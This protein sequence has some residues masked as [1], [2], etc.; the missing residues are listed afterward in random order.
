MHPPIHP[1]MVYA[2]CIVHRASCIVH[3]VSCIVRGASCVVRRACVR[4]C[5]VHQMPA[6][7]R[8]AQG[9]LNFRW[10]HGTGAWRWRRQLYAVRDPSGKRLCG[11]VNG[12]VMGGVL[13]AAQF[14]NTLTHDVL[15]LWRARSVRPYV[16]HATWMRQ[17][18]RA[19]HSSPT[20]CGRNLHG[21]PAAT[22]EWLRP[23]PPWV[24]GRSPRGS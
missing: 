8:V 24:L 15:Q 22:L 4:A 10:K 13:P 20:P 21:A 2:S 14:T 6:W 19:R 16:L 17:Q 3:G 5:M 9:P 11:L 18:V 12:T 23:Q 7:R 1:S